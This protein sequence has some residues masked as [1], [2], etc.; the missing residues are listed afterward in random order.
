M[1]DSTLERL[2]CPVDECGAKLSRSSQQELRCKE[3]RS[4][5]PILGGVAVVVPE[6]EEYILAHVKGIAQWVEDSEIP[7]SIRKQYLAM[8]RE[9]EREHIEE[10]LESERVN[11]L[12]FMT[13]YL[14]SAEA[15]TDVES[16]EIRQLITT[17]WDRGPFAK[18]AEWTQGAR[19]I[20]ELGC[21]VGGLAN[22]L[23][24]TV[25]DYLGVDSSFASVALA[26]SLYL[27]ERTGNPNQGIP[28]DLW[29]GP[30]ARR[31]DLKTLRKKLRVPAKIDFIVGDLEHPPIVSAQFDGCVALN[32]IDMLHHP[33]QLPT[34]Q[35]ALVKKGG[36]VIQCAPYIWHESVIGPLRKKFSKSKTSGELVESWYSNQGLKIEATAAHIPWVFFKHFRQ[37]ELYSVHGLI[38]RLS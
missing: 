22:R 20:I 37:V 9:L 7:K 5:F 24:S 11:A 2:I 38:A 19:S 21:G 33:E 31:I 35:K 23:P 25:S 14:S 29:L 8:K 3:C 17:C 6:A 27:G 13:H 10:D 1:K 4:T 34:I 12:Y 16:P 26:R 15:T 32:A 28:S 30:L 36:F 18:A